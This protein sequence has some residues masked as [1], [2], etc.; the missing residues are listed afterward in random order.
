MEGD[1]QRVQETLAFLA[2]V[3]GLKLVAF[4]CFFFFVFLPWVFCR[5]QGGNFSAPVSTD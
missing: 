4:F 5:G 3:K 2:Q 1:S